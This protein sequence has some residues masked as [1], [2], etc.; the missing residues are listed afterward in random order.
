MTSVSNTI[1]G[2][3]TPRVA[4]LSRVTLGALEDLN[5]AADYRQA[6]AYTVPSPDGIF[7]RRDAAQEDR[8]GSSEAAAALAKLKEHVSRGMIRELPPRRMPNGLTV[9]DALGNVV[10][11]A[12][13]E[14][15]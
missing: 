4:D 7:R 14:H 6:N 1:L 10:S 5:Y 8:L 3:S 9:L 15:Q 12:N 11:T 2:S 13:T